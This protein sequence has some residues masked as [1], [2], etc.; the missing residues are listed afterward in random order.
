MKKRFGID[1]D[2]T[3]T[4]SESL[5][6]FINHDFNLNLKMED[7]TE[8]E[9]T[10]FVNVS[11]KEFNE[12]FI[13]QEAK[14]YQQSPIAE[15]AAKVL[16]KWEDHSNLIFISAR[17]Q[18]MQEI[19]AEWLERHGIHYDHIEL[20]GSH[21]KIS[22]AKRLRVDLFL[23]DKH[24]NA[25]SIHEECHIPVLLFDTP[26]NRKPIPKGVIRVSN[27]LEAES[28]VSNWLKQVSR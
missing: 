12:W 17:G 27:W 2:G 21:D 22:T 7:I 28:W 5:L 14:I 3:V 8:Y 24:D 1:I 26:Y 20:V 13:K 23:E 10:P 9:L 4:T 18:K 25:V 11:E 15:N 6:P 19:T 16:N